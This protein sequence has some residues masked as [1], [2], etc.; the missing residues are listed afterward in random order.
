MSNALAGYKAKL[1]TS[2]STGGTKTNIAE[3]RDWTIRQSHAPI[4]VTSHDSSGDREL[5]KGS[6]QWGGNAAGLYVSSGATHQGIQDV[7][8][9]RTKVDMEA[10]PTGSSS[11]GYF[12]GEIFITEFEAS[13][14]NEDAG[15]YN[16]SFEG[17][18]VLTSTSTG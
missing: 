8:A 10:F 5:I 18:G 13:F 6:G 1:Y 9:G 4:N 15:A 11:Q 16:L 2:T 12:S 17:H 3:L 14:P 7:L